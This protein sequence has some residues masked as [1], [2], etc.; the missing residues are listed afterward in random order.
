MLADRDFTLSEDFALNSGTE[1][2]S[3]A[4]TRG[5]K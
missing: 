3:P 1:L 5:K 4:F 2:L